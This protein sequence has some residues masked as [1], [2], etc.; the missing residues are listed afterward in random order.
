MG[1]YLNLHLFSTSP[2]SADGPA[3]VEF[4]AVAF[5]V[6]AS[7]SLSYE[8]KHLFQDYIVQLLQRCDIS[9]GTNKLV[10]PSPHYAWAPLH[11]SQPT[12]FA[13][14]SLPMAPQTHYHPPLSI[15]YISLNSATFSKISKMTAEDWVLDRLILAEIKEWQHW[16][17]LQ[18]FSM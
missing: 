16:K 4:L 11:T 10:R 5:L 6:E 3:P 13:P 7:L 9:F 8:W 12:R 14:P 2:M 18:L 17:V 15:K 1:P